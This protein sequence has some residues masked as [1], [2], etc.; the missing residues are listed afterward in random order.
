[1]NVGFWL[2]ALYEVTIEF[3]MQG[4]KG[5]CGAAGDA[6]HQVENILAYSPQPTA[7]RN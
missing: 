4:S 7:Q 3:S 1:M 6:E 2:A 5:L